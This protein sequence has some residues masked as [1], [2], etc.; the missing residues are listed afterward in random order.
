MIGNG[1]WNCKYSD[2]FYFETPCRDCPKDEEWPAWEDEQ[3]VYEEPE[4]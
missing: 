4:T 3:D 2:Y 1:C